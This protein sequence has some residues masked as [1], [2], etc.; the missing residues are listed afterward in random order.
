MIVE[1][2]QGVTTTLSMIANG[3]IPPPDTRMRALPPEP[4]E[5][6]GL[7]DLYLECDFPEPAE[8]ETGD[9][10]DPLLAYWDADLETLTDFFADICP[11]DIAAELTAAV[12]ETPG[13]FNYIIQRF[14]P[15]TTVGVNAN[16][17]RKLL[18][19]EQYPFREPFEQMKEEMAGAGMPDFYIEEAI[20]SLTQQIADCDAWRGAMTE[21][22]PDE[23]G[24]YPVLILAGQFDNITPPAWAETAASLLPNAQ[25][26]AIPNAWHS[27]MGNNGPCPSDIALQFLANSGEA[28]DAGCTDDMKVAVLP[29]SDDASAAGGAGAAGT[30]GAPGLGDPLYPTLGNGG[31]DVQHYDITLDADPVAN[32]ISATVAI[33]AVATQDLSAFNLDFVGLTIDEVT[34][35]ASQAQFSRDGGELTIT[36]E[37]ALANEDAFRVQVR[38]HGEPEVINDPS[39]PIPLGWQV[40]DGGTFAVSEPSGSMNWF[41]G[42]NHPAD[43]ATYAFRIAT[44]DGY[45]VAA[46]GVLSQTVAGEGETTYVWVMDDPMASYLATV[47]INDYDVV[48]S[49]AESGAPIRNYFLNDTPD[50]VRAIFDETGAMIDYMTDLIAPYPF[51][52]YGVVLLREPASWALETQTLST[53]GMNGASDPGMTMHELSH[54]WFGNSV[55]PATWQDIWLNEGFAKYFEN[56]WLEHMGIAPMDEIM[57][58]LYSVLAVEGA[59]PPALPTQ[60]ELFGTG[61]YYRGAYT[62]HALRKTVGDDLFF[63]ILR[64]YYQRYQG[65]SASTADFMAVAAELGGA[66]AKSIL[67]D[68]LYSESVPESV[69]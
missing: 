19:T 68:W 12:N 34:V 50:D 52:V 46:N 16:I 65:G 28:V 33:D 38:Y 47:Q 51:D 29:P 41:P 5:A 23:Y 43:K 31:Y 22:T 57:A 7:L 17:N 63:D 42:N 9:T 6:A 56:L 55:S 45:E 14:S 54:S 40:Q 11:A 48:T 61:S 59:N 32:V 2:S 36:P 4:E 53:Y 18:C 25:L 62:L 67:Q 30:P 60:E 10:P 20:E 44:P 66:E 64:E 49:T 15:G 27:I 58:D 21:P 8:D 26:V 37:Q 24:A 3:E 35:D 1:L 13:I 69:E 39:A